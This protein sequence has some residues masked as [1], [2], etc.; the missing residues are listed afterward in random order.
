[1]TIRTAEAN[2]EGSLK[3]GKGKMRL[4]S[5]AFDGAY[6][7]SSPLKKVKGLTRRN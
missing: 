7:F 3:D 1:M 5:G 2:W 4:G 6:S